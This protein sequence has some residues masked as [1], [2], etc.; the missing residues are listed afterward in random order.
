[1][2]CKKCQFIGGEPFLYRGENSETVLDLA[3]AA[4]NAGY[5]FVEIFT[6]ATLLTRQKIQTIHELG[7]HIAV[8]L[9][10]IDPSVHDRITRTPGSFYKTMRALEWLKDAG[11]PTRVEVILMRTNQNTIVETLKW[12][13]DN[14]FSSK[15]PD[16]LR[17]NGRGSRQELM[18]DKRYIIEYGLMLQPDFIIDESTLMRNIHGNSCLDG[19][20]TITE[21]GDVLP[22]IFSREE[23]IGN[24]SQNTLRETILNP[25]LQS[26]WK[27]TMDNVLI[28]RDCEYRYACFDCR[29]LAKASAGETAEYLSAP[30]ARCTYN[31]Y[32]GQWAQGV[33]KLD[34]KGEPFYDLKFGEIIQQLWQGQRRHN[35]GAKPESL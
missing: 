21:T 34:E 17:P 4:K 18:P 9:Y 6:N 19:K 20:I 5:E 10:S 27:S 3:Q 30:P 22:C 1:M 24:V 16:L 33:W 23:V 13:H 8:S 2:G 11:I 31:P 26:I 35:E 32:T 12:I 7:L 25:A 29:P 14:G 28:C 15:S